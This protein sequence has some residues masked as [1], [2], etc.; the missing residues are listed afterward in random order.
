MLISFAI[1]ACLTA[2]LGVVAVLR[3]GKVYIEGLKSAT[4]QA[5]MLALRLPLALLTAGFL[6]EVM[7]QDL[8]ATWMGN[9]SGWRGIL[10]ASALGTLMPIGPMVLIPIAVAF[11]TVGAGVPQV[12]AFISGWSVL[13]LHRTIA[14]ELPMLGVNFTLVRMLSSLILPPLAG[15]SAAFIALV[16]GY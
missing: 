9:A 1:L 4:D 7:P 13:A 15:L 16:L 8:V 10:I 5:R 12:I 6:I 2:G 11:F 14:W 3:P